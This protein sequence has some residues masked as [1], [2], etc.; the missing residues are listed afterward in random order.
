M[1][2]YAVIGGDGMLGH[3]LVEFFHKNKKEVIGTT[4]RRDINQGAVFLD[5]LQENSWGNILNCTDVVI[6]GGITNYW[7]CKNNP[8]AVYVN[9][10]C[11]PHLVLFLSKHD[12]R[13]TFI[14]SNTVFNGKKPWPKENDDHCPVLDYGQQKSNAEKNI[15]K[16]ISEAGTRDFIKIVRLTKILTMQTSPIPD[17]IDS[18]SKAQRTYVFK[19]LIFAPVTLDYAVRNLIHI[20]ESTEPGCFHISGSENIDYVTFARI[21]A[22]A[23]GY[24]ASL[25]G[26]TTSIEAGVEI[27]FLPKYSGLNMNKTTKLFGIESQ[28]IQ[29]LVEEL[30]T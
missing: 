15:L 20:L 10:E 6:V 12:I 5:F 7:E 16:M 17:W 25:V 9:E 13:V 4:R 30:C 19:D 21:L 27:L 22:K 11:I 28:N 18:W 24:P 2:R 26:E 3:K 14:S 29:D 1:K 8:D 23:L